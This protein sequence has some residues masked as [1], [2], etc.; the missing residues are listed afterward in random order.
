MY[1]FGSVFVIFVYYQASLVSSTIAINVQIKEDFF[2][3]VFTSTYSSIHLFIYDFT[4]EDQ[5]HKF[6][7][8]FFS[9][10]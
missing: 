1:V 10:F 5:G 4:E 3:Y 7:L 8:T 6:S 9:E 2:L